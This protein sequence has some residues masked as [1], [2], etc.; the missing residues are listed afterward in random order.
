VGGPSGSNRLHVG[1]YRDDNGNAHTAEGASPRTEA[2]TLAQDREA[3][4]LGRPGPGID[5]E[6]E[7]AEQ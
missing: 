6:S 7:V 5:F 3:E 2:L 4:V 1:R